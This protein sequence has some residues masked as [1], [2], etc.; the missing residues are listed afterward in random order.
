MQVRSKTAELPLGA[1][2]R[3][4]AA[5]FR[6][7]SRLVVYLVIAAM[8]LVVGRYFLAWVWQLWTYAERSHQSIW[9]V[10]WRSL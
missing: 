7:R 4:H 10:F 3:Y 2:A 9:V 1:L 5:M 8:G 6:S